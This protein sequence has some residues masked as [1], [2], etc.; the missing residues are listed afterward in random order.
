MSVMYERWDTSGTQAC[1]EITIS[2]FAIGD[3]IMFA[4]SSLIERGDV[5][6][7]QSLRPVLDLGH[8]FNAISLFNP[9]FRDSRN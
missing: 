1:I 2:N 6:L 7:R 9:K 8:L 5:S 3:R 4:L